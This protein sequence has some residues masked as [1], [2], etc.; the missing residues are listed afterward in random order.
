MRTRRFGALGL[1]LALGLCAGVAS[2]GSAQA[3]DLVVVNSP[4]GVTIRTLVLTPPEPNAMV[5]LILIPGGTGWLD[6]NTATGAPQQLAQNFL[7]R[8]RQGF[9]GLGFRTVVVDAPS[10]RQNAAGMGGGFRLTGE[11]ATDLA[12]VIKAFSPPRCLQGFTIFGVLFCIIRN[13]DKWA[14]RPVAVLGMSAGAISAARAAFLPGTTRPNPDVDGIGLVSSVTQGTDAIQ[15]AP[16]AS[17]KQPVLFVHHVN[18]GCI[19]SKYRNA[20]REA[21]RMMVASV[22][23]G[24]VEISGTP[25]GPADP[26]DPDPQINPNPCGASDEMGYTLHGF[27]R[28][29]APVLHALRQW[30]VTLTH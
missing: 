2:G 10:D 3:D 17:I 1:M 19:A 16:L 11:H 28:A 27:S 14:G 29:G 21:F 6:V 8:T 9:L 24:F 25:V 26:D 7:V 5:T 13:P 15:G 23:T 4:R 30:A 18:D 12:A 20:T 22:N